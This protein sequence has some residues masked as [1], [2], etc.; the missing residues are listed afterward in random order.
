MISNKSDEELMLDYQEGSTLAFD[1]LYQRYKSKVFAYVNRRTQS[2]DE[3][4]E[5]FQQVFLKLHQSKSS[6]N[7]NYAFTQWLFT[8]CRTSV[9]DFYRSKKNSRFEELNENLLE[10]TDELKALEGAQNCKNLLS[11]ELSPVLQEALTLRVF[12]EESYEDIAL[13]LNVSEQNVRQMVSRS[14]RKLKAILIKSKED[15]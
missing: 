3:A 10:G 8:I 12:N 5:I 1:V 9:A 13:K 2:S 6:F 14:L 15:V 4:Y 7:D 11:K